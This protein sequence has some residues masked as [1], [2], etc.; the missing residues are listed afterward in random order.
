M[1]ACVVG[2]S[3]QLV[4]NERGTPK[5]TY[6]STYHV[7]RIRILGGRKGLE[8]FT[9]RPT[10][11]QQPGLVRPP[12]RTLCMAVCRE[13][14]LVRNEWRGRR[15]NQCACERRRLAN[16]YDLSPGVPTVK[17]TQKG[18]ENLVSD[19][20]VT[21]L[22]GTSASS[23]SFSSFSLKA[24]IQGS[25]KEKRR[26]RS[27]TTSPSVSNP[28]IIRGMSWSEGSSA[29]D[30]LIDANCINFPLRLIIW[31]RRQHS[32]CP[33]LDLVPD[34]K[35]IGLRKASYWYEY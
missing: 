16:R 32:F 35:K 20:R 14:W 9:N 6:T 12:A 8:S 13:C 23:P 34:L 19:V 26:E 29:V 7:V 25:P 31:M 2:C 5:E 10:S 21:S 30:P 17:K 24:F 33:W 22:G 4:V 1:S 15:Q 28:L 3:L 18:R 11:I 27:M